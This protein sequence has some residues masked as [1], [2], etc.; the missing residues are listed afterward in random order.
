MAR[1]ATRKVNKKPFMQ[2]RYAK[3]S[4]R[5]LTRAQYKK[6][7]PEQK[8]GV[9][10]LLFLWGDTGTFKDVSKHNK[11]ARKNKLDD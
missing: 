1:K 10:D 5:F 6:L 9:H 2:T 4:S 7:S 8:K 3:K 11:F